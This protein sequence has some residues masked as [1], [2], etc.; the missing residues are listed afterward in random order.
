MSVLWYD[1]NLVL[2]GFDINQPRASKTV[3]EISRQSKMQ[4]WLEFRIAT[5]VE[6]EITLF[7]S[8]YT[9]DNNAPKIKSW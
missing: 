5:T 8:V 4:A 2:Q 9:L 1:I 3:G 7:E 6:V